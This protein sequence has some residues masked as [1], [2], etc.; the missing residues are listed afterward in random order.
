MDKKNYEYKDVYSA[1]LEYFN[2]DDLAA[3]VWISKYCM[4]ETDDNGKIIYHE[5]T[6]DDMHHRLAH[7]FYRAGLKYNN[8]LSEQAIYETF[9]DFKYIVPQ[10]RPMAGIGIDDAVS[11][12]NCFVVGKPNQDS[13]GT[14][15]LIDQQI[16]QISKR[17][18]GGG[19]DLSRY[20]PNGSKVHNAAM[21][22][23]GPIDISANRFSNTIR[24]VG[25]SGRRGA[26]LMSMSINHPD[27]ERFMDCK[28]EEGKI[29]GANISLKLYDKWISEALD[30]NNP[31]KEKRRLWNKIIHNAT[32]KAEPGVL[33][34]DTILRESVADCYKKYG[35]ETTCTN[36][37]GEIP[38]C[39]YD[40]CRLMLLNLY[41]YVINPYTD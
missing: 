24:E 3:S 26:L 17:G 31:D 4:K 13:Y 35:F 29:T 34:W 22:S 10:G 5:L 11:I 9:K 28:M 2:G 38:L 36:P 15:A 41:S 20:R 40:S 16:M 14:I 37:C 32:A 7:E 27:A 18:G 30:D 6:P 25:Q 21:T 12:S 8:P 33:F 23:S 39:P 1:T 19:T